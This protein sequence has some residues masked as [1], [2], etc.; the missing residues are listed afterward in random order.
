[1]SPA[2]SHAH[3]WDPRDERVL[4]DQI[5]AYDS[6][7][8]Q[9]P[10]AHS[11]YLHWS[12]FTHDQTLR[13]LNDHE[14]F[15]NRVSERVS[16]PNGMDPPEHTPFRELIEPYF[17]PAAM[18]RFEPACKA[19][20]RNL[21]SA[22]PKGPTEIM[23]Q[24]AH[25]YALEVQCTFMGWP[26]SLHQPL[27][28]WISKNHA[29]TLAQDRTAMER[30]AR[31]F[32]GYMLALINERRLAGTDAPDDTTTRLTR[33]RVNGRPL[34]DEELISILRNWTV[35]ELGTIAAS[36]GIVAQYLATHPDVQAQLRNQ[37]ELVA[38]AIDEILRIHAPLISNRRVA[39]KPVK[40]GEHQ[41]RAGDRISVLWAS[42]NRDEAVFGD[43]D[44]FRLDRDP[45]LNLLYGAGV[46]VCPG[47][48][49]ARMELKLAVQALL[50]CTRQ[51]RPSPEHAPV[52]AR[53]PGSGFTSLI[54]EV[55]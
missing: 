32:D 35:G 41:L 4:Q 27:R 43:P 44:E 38:P 24:L 1:M 16:V 9:C 5:T 39:T 54:L 30:V 46:H 6:M 21:A 20:A 11:E 14:T 34:S 19:I 33:E 10:V 50:G 25:P 13:I 47:A 29:A 8:K 42:A 40:L 49:L 15:S 31:E 12:V 26:S 48:P 45:V 17:G 7:R 53:Y 23:A 3:H 28:E 22:L 2:C 52:R 37:P 55:L 36:V 18:A 51:I